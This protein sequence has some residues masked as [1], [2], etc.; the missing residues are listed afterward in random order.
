MS[1]SPASLWWDYIGLALGQ[2]AAP[3]WP[4]GL[5]LLLGRGRPSHELQDGRHGALPEDEGAH[6]HGHHSPDLQAAPAKSTRPSARPSLDFCSDQPSPGEAPIWAK[7]RVSSLT[8]R[9][10]FLEQQERKCPRPFKKASICH[11]IPSFLPDLLSKPKKWEEGDSCQTPCSFWGGGWSP[12]KTGE[13]QARSH[14]RWE[15]WPGHSA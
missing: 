9:D 4:V 15:Q 2:G 3:G 8:C 7:V 5:R 12:E 1:V 13:E 10:G 11:F 14:T 6:E